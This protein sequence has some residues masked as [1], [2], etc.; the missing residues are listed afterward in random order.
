MHIFVTVMCLEWFTT[1]RKNHKLPHSTIPPRVI[2]NPLPVLL[3]AEIQ[4]T[5]HVTYETG[6]TMSSPSEGQSQPAYVSFPR[7]IFY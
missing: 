1:S 2:S 5:G 7:E 6:I 3:S 4:S